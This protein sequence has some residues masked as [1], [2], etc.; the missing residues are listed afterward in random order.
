MDRRFGKS[1]NSFGTSGQKGEIFTKLTLILISL[2]LSLI[3]LESALRF[4][5]PLDARK[6]PEFR[7]PHPV[8]GW[9]LEPGA[10]YQYQMPED[11]V[12]VT[13]NS[14]GQHDLE[15][16]VNKP[17]RVF[18]ILI[19]GD[20]FMEAYSVELEDAFHRRVEKLARA[21]G[22]NVEV[23]N[24]GVAGYGTLQEYLAFREKGQFYKP[25]LVLLGFFPANDIMNNSAELESMLGP[26]R[27]QMLAR[28]FLDPND[29]TLW[30]II[31]GDFEG[32]QHRFT[33]QRAFLDAQRRQITERLILL[34]LTRNILSRLKDIEFSAN[35]R[36]NEGKSDLLEVERQE[37]ALLGVNY[38]DEPSEYTSAWDTT[39]RILSRLK[40]DVDAVGGQFVIFTVPALEEINFESYEKVN[41][42]IVFRDK[43][44]IEEAPGN[45][46]LSQ[47]L[48]D[49][50][51]EQITLL[52][53]FRIAS[54]DDR[55]LLYHLSDQHWN[56]EGHSL[57]AELV[58]SK[59]FERGLLPTAGESVP[60]TP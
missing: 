14:Q 50:D 1:S 12:T 45:M 32:A 13:Y 43:L 52:P 27:A 31:P 34:R 49:L 24:L 47:I 51:I 40:A 35:S 19:L 2:C 25:D 53:D 9:A 5:I 17:D 11:I 22:A 46:R 30:T 37:L 29:P 42:P 55:M 44:C 21:A 60:F 15:H 56:T 23:I 26:A 4:F 58:V 36:I 16:E 48:T 10:S 8:L 57:A 18:R 39:E 41:A 38:C 6:P 3:L 7:V 20:S 59:L 28:P 33:E 54:R